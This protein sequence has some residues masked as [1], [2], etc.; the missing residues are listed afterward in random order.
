MV[1]T[2]GSWGLDGGLNR[3]LDTLE[4]ETVFELEVKAT[5][6]PKCPSPWESSSDSLLYLQ[7]LEPLRR[8]SVCKV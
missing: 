5:K 8:A 6:A 4:E 3:L 1:G 2:I 7:R